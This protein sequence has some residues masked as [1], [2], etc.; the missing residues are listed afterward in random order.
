M[1]IVRESGRAIHPDDLDAVAEM[2]TAEGRFEDAAVVLGAEEACRQHR[3]QPIPVVYVPGHDRLLSQVAAGLESDAFAKAW[4]HGRG[5]SV[6]EAADLA[7]R[8][9]A[10]RE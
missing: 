5:L 1:R 4:S 3:R 2:L 9:P 10:L 8:A 7:F 6:D